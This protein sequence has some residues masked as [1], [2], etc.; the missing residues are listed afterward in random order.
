MHGLTGECK[1]A[2]LCHLSRMNLTSCS[3]RAGSA[4]KSM[5]S[6]KKNKNVSVILQFIYDVIKAAFSVLY[7][8][9]VTMNVKIFYYYFIIRL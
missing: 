7:Y 3:V 8:Y 6:L 5:H 2:C 9:I 1:L 4:G